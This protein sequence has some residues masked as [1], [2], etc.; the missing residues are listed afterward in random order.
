MGIT[1]M[2]Y[3]VY[4]LFSTE[5]SQFLHDALSKSVSRLHAA[6]GN[7]TRDKLHCRQI[8][9]KPLLLSNSVFVYDQETLQR[10]SH[11][12]CGKKTA[13]TITQRNTKALF[14]SNFQSSFPLHPPTRTSPLFRT[15]YL[16]CAQSAIPGE[17][18]AERGACCKG[19]DDREWVTI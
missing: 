5:M 18:K 13:A 3:R 8:R 15:V 10:S 11:N 6:T 19:P 2:L 9:T 16:F 7:V 14:L 17:T 1:G 12:L 4:I